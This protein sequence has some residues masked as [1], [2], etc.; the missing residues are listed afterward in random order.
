M[1]GHLYAKH[2]PLDKTR[3]AVK[4]AQRFYER[5]PD[6]K[7]YDQTCTDIYKLITKLFEMAGE[8]L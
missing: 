7:K 8:T 2:F 5:V 3:V 6:D 4:R 1:E